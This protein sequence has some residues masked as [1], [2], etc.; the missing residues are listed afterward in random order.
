MDIF[1]QSRQFI[2]QLFNNQERNAYFVE[3][4]KAIRTSQAEGK[5]TEKQELNNWHFQGSRNIFLKLANGDG[6][7]KLKLEKIHKDKIIVG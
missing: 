7:A 1:L 3:G 2:K 4:K 6:G 5:Y